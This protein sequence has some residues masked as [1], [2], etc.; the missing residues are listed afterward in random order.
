MCIIYIYI[1]IYIYTYIKSSTFAGLL[2]EKP[3]NQIC[4][5]KNVRKTP[6]NFKKRTCLFTKISL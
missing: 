5:S 6:E 2:I 4:Y 1:Y 3:D